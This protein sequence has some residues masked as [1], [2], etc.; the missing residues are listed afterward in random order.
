M[1]ITIITIIPIIIIIIAII[2]ILLAIMRSPSTRTYTG[3]MAV[4]LKR[5]SPDRTEKTMS[6][7]HG[8]GVEDLLHVLGLSPT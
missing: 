3:A 6:P 4:S 5:T 8:G 7:M 1:A 2:V